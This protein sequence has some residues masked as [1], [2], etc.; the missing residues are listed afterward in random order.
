MAYQYL[1][2]RKSFPWIN[3][4][5]L[6]D[7]LKS[8]QHNLNIMRMCKINENA[9]SNRYSPYLNILEICSYMAVP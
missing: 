9:H 1:E 7:H 5:L 2:E 4:L 3:L 8:L 6:E